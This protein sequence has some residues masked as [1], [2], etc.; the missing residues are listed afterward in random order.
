M[1]VRQT[2]PVTLLCHLR[3][4]LFNNRSKIY[5]L[6]IEW[7]SNCTDW[8]KKWNAFQN[9][10]YNLIVVIHLVKCYV[11]K[12]T[13]L[14]FIKSHLIQRLL[15]DRAAQPQVS[16]I[17]PWFLHNHQRIQSRM[18]THCNYVVSRVWSIVWPPPKRSIEIY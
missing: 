16:M 14:F 18:Y 4:L 2:G 17:S 7:P 15:Q 12:Y 6:L 10:Q 3:A 9:K 11:A 13:A 5:E 1:E 8:A